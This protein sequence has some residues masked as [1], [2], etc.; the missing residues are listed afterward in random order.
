MDSQ[1][2]H[3]SHAL[4]AHINMAPLEKRAKNGD[5]VMAVTGNLG[6]GNMFKNIDKQE[7]TVTADENETRK[8]YCQGNGGGLSSG[9]EQISGGSGFTSTGTNDGNNHNNT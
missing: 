7:L 1:N 4:Q 3:H 6:R 2:P 8:T 9:N 5:Q